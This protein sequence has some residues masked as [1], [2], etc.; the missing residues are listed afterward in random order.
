ME[1]REGAKVDLGIA[2]AQWPKYL[3]FS[4]LVAQLNFG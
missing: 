3:G 1:G 4:Y 2:G